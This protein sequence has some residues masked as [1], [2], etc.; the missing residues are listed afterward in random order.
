M[1]G[2]KYIVFIS[3]ALADSVVVWVIRICDPP[4]SMKLLS[5]MISY[6]AM[7]V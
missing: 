7:A 4:K 2:K 6:L 1:N 3:E 5:S